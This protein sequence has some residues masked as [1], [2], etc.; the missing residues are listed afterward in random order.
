MSFRLVGGLAI[1]WAMFGARGGMAQA[2]PP[3]STSKPTLLPLQ[4]ERDG[5][6]RASPIH[7]TGANSSLLKP[8]SPGRFFKTR[9]VILSAAVYGAG[10]AD[11]HQTL[12]VR[13]YSWWY[14]TDSL[15]RPFARLPAPAYY[16][17]GLGVGDRR[18]LVQLEDGSFASLAQAFR[19]SAGPRHRRQPL[20]HPFQSPLID[21]G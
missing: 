18:Q 20:R 19:H 15:A 10:L 17:T 7:L 3:D 8:T 5:S 4:T 21:S 2:N 12:E 11:M 6:N 16:A 1:I 9:F 14:E 13:K